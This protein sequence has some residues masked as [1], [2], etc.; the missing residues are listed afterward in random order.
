LGVSFNRIKF[1]AAQG[2]IETIQI[3]S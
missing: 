3:K 2:F 1:I